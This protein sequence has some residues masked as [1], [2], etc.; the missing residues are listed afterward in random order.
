M[1]DSEK[2]S[3]LKSLEQIVKRSTLKV[4]GENFSISKNPLAISLKSS[5]RDI[6]TQFDCQLE[7]EITSQIQKFFPGEAILGEEASKQ[8]EA[9]KQ[10]DSFWCIDPIDGTTNFSQGYPIYC[11]TVA[12]V[13]KLPAYSKHQAT[14]G[15]IYDSTRH[16]YF[17]AAQD[18]GAWKNKQR[19]HV[20]QKEKLEN[21]V[22]IS[23][24]AGTNDS[25]ERD[26][27]FKKFKEIGTLAR[28]IRR[29]GSA[30]LNLAY[31]ANKHFDVFWERGLQ[32]WD[33][34]AGTIICREAGAQVSDFSSD[35]VDLFEG[36]II[37]CGNKRLHK[38][39]I[40]KLNQ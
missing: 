39:L 13:Q 1:N 22:V 27:R 17:E 25:S 38:W 19:L 18:L 11:H 35:A 8:K 40:K 9:F 7:E 12:F 5:N 4:L 32:P 21:C 29:D 2:F 36:E 30:A 24:F 37:T 26:L 6:V 10:L 14:I 34:A 16:E 3:R 31:T 15:C 20:S 33:I 23:G 28:G